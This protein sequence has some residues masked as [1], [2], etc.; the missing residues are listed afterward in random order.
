WEID[1][2]PETVS[3]FATETYDNNKALTI[4]FT[5]GG[6]ASFFMV[7]NV[8]V[9]PD[10]VY[11]LNITST[12]GNAHME[13]VGSKDG[14]TII[15]P[16]LLELGLNILRNAT[17]IHIEGIGGFYLHGSA[18]AMAKAYECTVTLTEAMAALTRM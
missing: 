10:K 4:G 12:V 11:V 5:N 17:E 9:I 3:C 16:N 2:D 14:L 13:F 18:A 15:A 6:H 8:T 7:H 1:A